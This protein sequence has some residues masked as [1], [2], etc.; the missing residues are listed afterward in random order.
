MKTLNNSARRAVAAWTLMEI[1][2]V[3]AIIAILVAIAGA[4][5][6]P[7]FHRKGFENQVMNDL[8]Q[9]MIA[10]A[11][12]MAD[13]DGGY[14]NYM[15][16]LSANAPKQ[17]QGWRDHLGD[18]WYFKAGEGDGAYFLAYNYPVR[19]SES[20]Y[21]QIFKY[22]PN[23]DYL[24]KSPLIR[25]MPGRRKRMTYRRCN[26]KK[27]AEINDTAWIVLVGYEDGHVKWSD[28]NDPFYELNRA[29]RGE[30]FR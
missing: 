9:E 27:G 12:Y 19:R 23:V 10:I 22:D 21:P 8:R 14:P 2:I 6:A 18:P 16:S 13:N 7:W 4:A 30:G 3:C 17:V 15:S 5:V 11:G 29:C 26:A 25:Q 1:L 24:V 28:V 20:D